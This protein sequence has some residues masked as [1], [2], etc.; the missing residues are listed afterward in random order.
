M[1]FDDTARNTPEHIART[2]TSWINTRDPIA[3]DIDGPNGLRLW[4]DIADHM[5]RNGILV[6]AQQGEF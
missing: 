3:V 4:L 1:F 2:Q 5:D 6:D